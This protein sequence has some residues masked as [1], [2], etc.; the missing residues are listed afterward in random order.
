MNKFSI[1][2]WIPQRWDHIVGNEN[3]VEHFKDTLKAMLAG[4]T[5]G[6]NTMILGP[7]GT[8]KTATTTFFVSC[9]LCDTP[10]PVTLNPCN[11]CQPCI[12]RSGQI[13][14]LGLD[15]IHLAG[16]FHFIPID[17]ADCN[18]DDIRMLLKDVHSYAE[19]RIVYLDEVHRLHRPNS[20]LEDMLLI[21]TRR[22]DVMWI[23]SLISAGDLKIEFQK[24][25]MHVYTELPTVESLSLWLANRCKEWGIV[26]DGAKTL[27]LL[28]EKANCV[29]GD[30]L[31]V[32]ARAYK[33]KPRVLEKK[34]VEKHVFVK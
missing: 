12:R 13:G 15:T 31:Q 28:A 26:V 20:P 6:L 19:I 24:R 1:E 10:D 22:T 11:V 34:L 5:K 33:K 25:F 9:L 18:A 3:L 17:C 29:P 32:L 16:K 21:P 30:T 27:I 14:Q 8:G 2:T 4:D 7:S 23:G